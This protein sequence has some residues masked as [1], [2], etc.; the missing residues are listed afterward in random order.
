MFRK[1]IAAVMAAI[2]MA[3]VIPIG[4][5]AV[6]G[7]TQY[8]V[9]ALENALYHELKPLAADFLQAER[10]YGVNALYLAGIA[11]LESGWGRYCFEE[12]NIFG[13]Y[14]GK[15]FPSKSACIDYVAAFM[16][17]NYLSQGGKYY[18]GATLEGINCYWNGNPQWV[19]EVE[20]IKTQ[21]ENRCRKYD[22]GQRKMAAGPYLP[23]LLEK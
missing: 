20:A 10:K 7:R 1:W 13:F 9:E 4:A 18:N 21:I 2:I 16:R 14:C 17:E 15:T 22:Q 23:V 19:R 6:S 3:F 8:S 5:G 11:A 12:N